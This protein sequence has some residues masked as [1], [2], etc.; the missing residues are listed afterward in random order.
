MQ[1]MWKWSE[2]GGCLLN[3]SFVSNSLKTSQKHNRKYADVL[4]DE[5]RNLK[6][7]DAPLI[8]QSFGDS[9]H[10]LTALINTKLGIDPKDGMSLN[11]LQDLL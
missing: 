10:P 5:G 3:V 8:P 1:M 6:S 11:R 4:I 7:Q 9:I 2:S